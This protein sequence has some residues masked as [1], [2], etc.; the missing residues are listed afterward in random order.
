MAEYLDREHFIPLRKTELVDWLCDDPNLPAAQREPFRQFCRLVFATYHF[1]FNQRLD[2]LKEAYAPFDP[3]SDCKSVLAVKAEEKQRRFNH[4]CNEFAWLMEKA[5]FKHLSPDEIVTDEKVGE[6]GLRMH[7][8]FSIF[9]HLAVFARGDTMEKR[10]KRCWPYFWQK[11]E[12]KVPIY[13]RLVMILKLR[14]HARLPRGVDTNTVFLQVF[15]NIPK[16]D[17]KMLMPGARVRMT[18]LDRGKVGLPILSGLGLT[19]MKILN[20]V[21]Q[22]AQD[23]AQIFL[24]QH[25]AALWG[26]A[27]GTLG[28]GA[29]SYYSYQSTK[30]RYGL[31]LTQVLYYQNLDTNAGVLLRI[32]DEAEDQECREAVLGYYYLWRHAGEQGWTS[33]ALDDYIE[34]ELE[35]RANIKVDFEIGD[36]IA[37]LEKLRIIEKV[38]DRYRARPLDQALQILDWTWDNYFKFNNPEPES[39]PIK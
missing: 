24:F 21:A 4:L 6:W 14:P 38:G 36:A 5:N 35:R 31:T 25:P 34:L 20:D 3:D 22:F 19:G 37:K 27:T 28:Y 17:L 12:S 30:Q 15:K 23:M 32:L 33:P 16:N 11:E 13:Q 18:G 26:I 2:Q 7:V 8:D 29:K 10:Q 1:E 9:E 39:F